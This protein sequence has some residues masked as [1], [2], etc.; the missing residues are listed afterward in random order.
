MHT[1]K[2]G[3]K[4]LKTLNKYV[5]AP[6]LASGGAPDMAQDPKGAQMAAMASRIDCG[7]LS[8]LTGP[9]A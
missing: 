4:C 2:F 7:R 8:G 9:T 1:C 6:K 3:S 5:K